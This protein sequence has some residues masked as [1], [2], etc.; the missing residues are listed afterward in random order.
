MSGIISDNIGRSSGLVKAV[1]S[2][3]GG[4]TS[5]Q[6][7]TTASTMTAVA[8]NG[9]PINTTSN[10]CTVTLPASASVGDT[11]QFVDYARTWGTNNVTLDQQSLKF[12]GNDDPNPL[13]NTS[14]QSVTITYVDATK[15]WIPTVDDDTT[16]ETPQS[17]VINY[18]VIGAGGGGGTGQSAPYIRCGGGGG[19]GGYRATHNS[20]ASGGGGS[21]D[22]QLDIAFGIP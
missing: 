13:Y 1:A 20:E 22:T 16:F 9:Y 2:A 21:S 6:A 17:V 10:A 12:Q 18:L 7:V 14:G 11:I 15:G 4:G 19:A 5:W 3:G 8:G